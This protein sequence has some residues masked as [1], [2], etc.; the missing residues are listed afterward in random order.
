MNIFITGG[1]SGIGAC[2][3]KSLSNEHR[4]IAPLRQDLDLSA[5][6]L[7]DLEDFDVLILCAGSDN[8]GKK[9]FCSMHDQHWQNTMQVN[10]LS[11]MHLIKQ[12]VLARSDQWSKIIVFGSTAAD[13]IW[14][15]MLPYSLS[16]LSLE[17]FC[18]ALRQEISKTIGITIIKPGLV[19]TNFHFA[20]NLGN[21][22]RTEADQ[23]YQCQPCLD[24]D[25][26]VV[27][28]QTVISDRDHIWQEMTLSS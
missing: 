11:N 20:R 13:H 9:L 5:Y 16:K 10:L 22:S 6:C 24:P 27:P 21:I 8:D 12:F 14:P 18:Q 17:Y 7:C 3:H 26:F 1:S 19:R 4:V 23:W 2:L 25:D 28:V 15:G